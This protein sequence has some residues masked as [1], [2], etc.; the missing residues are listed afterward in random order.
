VSEWRIEFTSS[1]RRHLEK[2]HPEFR[3]RIETA[4][5]TLVDDPRP[6]SAKRLVGKTEYWR[7]RVGSY[8]VVYMVEDDRLVILVLA[9]G[10]RREVYRGL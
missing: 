7:I 9:L 8:R 5:A 3:R 2:I 10:H 1:A 6:A 4:I